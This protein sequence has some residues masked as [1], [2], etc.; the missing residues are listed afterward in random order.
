MKG[1][2]DGCGDGGWVVNVE[3]LAEEAAA[4]GSASTSAAVATHSVS[5]LVGWKRAE[6]SRDSTLL[7]R[8]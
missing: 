7:T 8:Y 3:Y 4:A 1:T 2:E 6:K 5:V